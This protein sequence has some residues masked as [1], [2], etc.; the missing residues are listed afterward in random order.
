MGT[1]RVAVHEHPE[2]GKANEAIRKALADHFHVAPSR[3]SIV[4]GT[5][6][7]QRL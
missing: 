6:P 5:P 2:K 3:I 1:Y 7:V 4:A